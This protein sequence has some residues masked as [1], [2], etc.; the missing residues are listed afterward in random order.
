MISDETLGLDDYKSLRHKIEAR[1]EARMKRLAV[2]RRQAIETLNEAW[3]KMGGST[4]DITDFEARE[5][6]LPQD[7]GMIIHNPQ[8]DN[9]INGSYK[10]TVGMKHVRRGAQGVFDNDDIEVVSQT[11]I[12]DKL[13]AEYPN[14][15]VQSLR[16]SISRLLRELEQQNKLILIEEGKGGA[17]NKYRKN[18]ETE[19]TIL[20]P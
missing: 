18:K 3:P 8:D 7:E 11:I 20:D 10:Y 9:S 13:L 14:A 4:K 19:A 16:V 15:D 1:F 2:E 17:P 12:K 6:T 5:E